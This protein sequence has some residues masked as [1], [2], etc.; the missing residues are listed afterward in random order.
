MK[1]LG[2]ALIVLGIVITIGIYIFTEEIDYVMG[3][4]VIVSIGSLVNYYG[5]KQSTEK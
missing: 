5:E 3:G 2:L 4:L 1:N